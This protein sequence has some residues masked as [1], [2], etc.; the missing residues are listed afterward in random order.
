MEKNKFISNAF[1]LLSGAVIT[2]VLGMVI[3]ITTTRYV[4][5]D[6]IGLYMLILPTFMLF[7]NLTTFGFPVAI[8]KLV[9]E[10]KKRGTSII[11]SVIPVSILLNVILFIIIYLSAPLISNLL[12][13]SRTYYPLLAIALVLPFISL[14]SI[15]RGYFFGKEKM[16]PHS[17]SHIFEQIIR[18]SL[19]IIVIPILL[20]KSLIMAITGV[21]LVNIVSEL[22]SIIILIFCVPKKTTIT[23]KD[24]IPD[25]KIIKDV[26]N[27]SIPTTSSRIIGSIGYFFEPIILTAVLTAIG[28]SSV[29]IISEYGI[30]NGYVLPLL[31]I[32]AFFAQ[33]ISSLLIPVISKGYVNKRT[34]YVKSKLNQGLGLSLLIGV[35]TTILFIINPDFFLKLIYKTTAGSEYLKLMAPFFLVYYLQIP[36][37][38]T[39]LAVG[40]AKE[41]MM[42]TIIGMIIKVLLLYLLSL[43]KIGL[44]ALIIAT[45]INIFIVTFLNYLKLRR[46]F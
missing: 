29:Y 38:S 24:I 43:L 40:K 22:T 8:S 26:L 3:K 17:I 45:I 10:N 20:K 28:Y 42:S 15:I 6:G 33:T 18:L 44:Y 13:D 37:T 16:I 25:P 11:F 12:H 23:K 39:L 41:A 5:L 46:V 34:I 27:I 32:P 9:A 4:G 31:M 35:T 21:V 30:I 36:L 1:I 14:S 19:I 7:I 2:K